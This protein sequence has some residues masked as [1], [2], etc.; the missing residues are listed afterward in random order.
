MVEPAYIGGDFGAK[1][2][3]VDEF[4]CYFLA[5]ATKRPIKAV[6]SYLDDMRST[7]VRH[8]STVFLKTAITAGGTIAAMIGRVVF[9]GGAFGAGKPIPTVLPAVHA[10]PALPYHI[11]NAS[12]EVMSVYTHTVPGGHV[13]SPGE[14]QILFAVESHLDMISM[15]SGPIRSRFGIAEYG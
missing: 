11:P 4:A 9:N 5:R 14:T 12:W 15:R 1:G 13:R 2:L 3:S 10:I 7:N 6:R 8:A